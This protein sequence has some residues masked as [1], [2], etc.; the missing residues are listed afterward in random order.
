MSFLNWSDD[1]ATGIP[2]VDNQH[3]R[4]VEY[5]NELHE[6][7]QTKNRGQVGVVLDELVEYTLS[8]FGFE[9]ELMGEA[10]YPFLH[11]HQKVHRLFEKKVGEFVERHKMGEDIA[12]PLLT[13]LRTWLVNHIKRD[14]H[15]YAD[16]VQAFLEVSGGAQI[17]KKKGFFARLFG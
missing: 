12:R 1:L 7:I 11:A 13:T 6:A 10:G 14:D 2:V 17:K 5:I 15:D 8:H 9:E 4:I 16:A 3:R